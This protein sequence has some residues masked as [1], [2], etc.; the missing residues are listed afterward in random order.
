M[1]ARIKRGL[2]STTNFVYTTFKKAVITLMLVGLVGLS[3][4]AAIVVIA[5]KLV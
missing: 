2:D 5:A 4:G 3:I 1:T